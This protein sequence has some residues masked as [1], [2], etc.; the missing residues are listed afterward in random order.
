[1]GDSTE[2]AVPLVGI[3]QPSFYRKYMNVPV[4]APWTERSPPVHFSAFDRQNP[5]RQGEI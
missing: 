1:V 2:I 3:G 4:Q 5:S